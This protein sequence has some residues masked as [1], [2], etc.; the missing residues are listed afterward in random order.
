M[1]K[2]NRRAKKREEIPVPIEPGSTSSA[3]AESQKNPEEPGSDPKKRERFPLHRGGGGRAS[4][5]PGSKSPSHPVGAVLCH[6]SLTRQTQPPN[7]SS[8]LTRRP[9][10]SPA[11]ALP[12]SRQRRRL[13][14]SPSE[15]VRITEMV[16]VV[17]R[18]AK[19]T[20]AAEHKTVR[21]SARRRRCRHR[22]RKA[23]LRRCA[24][25]PGDKLGND[26]TFFVGHVSPRWVTGSGPDG[27]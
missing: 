11:A 21:A 2:Q 4:P 27:T 3:E 20:T 18:E 9:F 8:C 26:V 22:P 19:G 17:L 14:V 15:F 13:G 5:S 7:R 10:G 6:R 23:R 12:S 24:T 1:F 16:D 25:D